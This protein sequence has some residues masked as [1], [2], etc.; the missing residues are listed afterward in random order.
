MTYVAVIS[1]AQEEFLA[2]L[3]SWGP[4]G[5]EVYFNV[6]DAAADLGYCDRRTIYQMLHQLRNKGLADMIKGDGR[7]LGK[8][9]FVCFARPEDCLVDERSRPKTRGVRKPRK[10]KPAAPRVVMA[11]P[12]HLI[13]YVGA[14][15]N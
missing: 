5:T 9:A 1:H 7:R 6:R 13:P 14:E 15:R 10:Q 12:K 11:A 8:T 2:Y 3:S 4:L